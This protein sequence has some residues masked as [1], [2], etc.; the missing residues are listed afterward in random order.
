MSWKFTQVELGKKMLTRTWATATYMNF[1]YLYIYGNDNVMKKTIL[2]RI[3][4]E[5]VRKGKLENLEP[6]VYDK[7]NNAFFS[8]VNTIGRLN[9]FY[10]KI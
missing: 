1:D 8:S 9:C 6:Y 4:L 7:N 10:Q 3:S 2:S 5:N